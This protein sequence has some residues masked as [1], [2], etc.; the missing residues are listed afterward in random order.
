MCTSCGCRNA[1]ASHG[2]GR[3]ITMADLTAAAAAAKIDVASVVD[4][5]IA[6]VPGPLKPSPAP[7]VSVDLAE[8]RVRHSHLYRVEAA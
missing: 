3:N 8:R 5:I 2:D 1:D 6:T 7:V 4:N